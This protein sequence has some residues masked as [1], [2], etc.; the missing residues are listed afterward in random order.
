MINTMVLEL[1]T[2]GLEMMKKEGG[3]Y[4]SISQ[5]ID[6]S[7]I[8]HQLTKVLRSSLCGKQMN[9]EIRLPDPMDLMQWTTF[10][11]LKRKNFNQFFSLKIC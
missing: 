3:A 10:N 9:Y 4:F 8:I 5:F 1:A 2:A 6:L 7:L 11:Q